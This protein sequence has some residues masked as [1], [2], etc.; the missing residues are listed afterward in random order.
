MIAITLGVQYKS[1]FFIIVNLNGF[2]NKLSSFSGSQ[3]EQQHKSPAVLC[4]YNTFF[5]KFII[6]VDENLW[7]SN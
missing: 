6:N 3:P 1:L 2:Q 4:K 7:H 5:A